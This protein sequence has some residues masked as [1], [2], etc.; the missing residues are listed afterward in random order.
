LSHKT[1]VLGS[2]TRLAAA[3]VDRERTGAVFLACR[4]TREGEMSRGSFFDRLEAAQRKFD[5]RGQG[6]WYRGVKRRSYE[7]VPSYLRHPQ[8]RG[9]EHNLMARF[10]RQGARYLDTKDKWERL[11]FMQHYGVPTKLIDWTTNP[12]AAIYFAL[13]FRAESRKELDKPHIWVLN[14]FGLN[15]LSGPRMIFDN[16]DEPTDLKFE[17]QSGHDWPHKWPIAIAV[18]WRNIRIEH[19]QGYL[20]T[21]ANTRSHLIS[22]TSTT[23]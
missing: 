6:V 1:T 9:K 22:S 12:T 23:P 2:T 21:M 10:A 19:Q 3:T 4:T 8:L 15:G 17:R 13:A 18:D 14:P 16:M 5:P 20:R 11:A 7:L